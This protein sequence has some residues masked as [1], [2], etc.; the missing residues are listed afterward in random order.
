MILSDFK[1]KHVGARAYIIGKGPSLDMIDSIRNVLDNSSAVIFCTNE[2]IHKV[3]SLENL[4]S[5]IYCVQQDSELEYDCIPQDPENIHFMNRI[6][7]AP[8]EDY[9]EKIPRSISPWNPDAVLYGP[10]EICEYN[11]FTAIACIRLAKYMGI[12]SVIFCCFDS[13]KDG[14]K[15][16]GEYAKCI[17]KV[18]SGTGRHAVHGCEILSQAKRIMKTIDTLCPVVVI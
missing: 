9:L 14:W 7:H 10:P 8:H 11:T 3:E 13:W 17:G 6:Q 15:G 16:S 4:T 5:T 2:S 18:Q 12:D 1:D